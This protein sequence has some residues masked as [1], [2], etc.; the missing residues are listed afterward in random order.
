MEF[1]VESA[2]SVPPTTASSPNAERQSSGRSDASNS[3]PCGSVERALRKEQASELAH[4]Q[5]PVVK[6]HHITPGYPSEDHI[7]ERRPTEQSDDTLARYFGFQPPRSSTDIGEGLK[8]SSLRAIRATTRGG[9]THPRQVGT[10]A[11]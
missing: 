11:A 1:R 9:H 10:D 2:R 8:S 3:A 6:P 4:A 5:L 7:V